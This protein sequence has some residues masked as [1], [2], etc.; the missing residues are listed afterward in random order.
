MSQQPREAHP[1]MLLFAVINVVTNTWACPL[2][3][4]EADGVQFQCIKAT[5]REICGTMDVVRFGLHIVPHIKRPR[6]A[7]VLRPLAYVKLAKPVV[8]GIFDFR[9]DGIRR[10][11]ISS[12]F[13]RRR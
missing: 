8:K 3:L 5:L 13:S 12:T 11:R 6:G 10:E 2:I 1:D 7:L 9:L 4:N